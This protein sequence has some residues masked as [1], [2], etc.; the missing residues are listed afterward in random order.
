MSFVTAFFNCNWKI[1]QKG[2]NLHKKSRRSVRSWE[3]R[4]GRRAVK[5]FRERVP[6]RKESRGWK[7]RGAAL[8]ATG[9]RA[10]SISGE[11][12][13][14][15]Q[16]SRRDGDDALYRSA[17][18][19]ISGCAGLS[20]N[21]CRGE[22]ERAQRA[23]VELIL[24]EIRAADSK[25]PIRGRE[26]RPTSSRR[27]DVCSKKRAV[28]GQYPGAARLCASCDEKCPFRSFWALLTDAGSRLF[29][30]GE[31]G[32]KRAFDGFSFRVRGRFFLTKRMRS[33]IIY[34]CRGGGGRKLQVFRWSIISSRGMLGCGLHG[35]FCEDEEFPSRNFS[36]WNYN[37]SIL[38]S[39]FWGFRS[40]RTL[41]KILGDPGL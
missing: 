29:L 25:A 21:S 31:T 6:I 37:Q 12:W 23:L 10:N 24:C 40:T 33:G 34:W 16:G 28:S 38:W 13:P 26:K 9:G 32:N 20:G 36:C 2:W 7:K 5:K 3:N 22:R 8:S 19:F 27:G 14:C 15:T 4:N 11:Y 30:R 35:G 1:F 17:R 41:F 39:L 18:T